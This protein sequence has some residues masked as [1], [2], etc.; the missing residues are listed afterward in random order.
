MTSRKRRQCRCD[1]FVVC[2]L[3]TPPH[4]ISSCF[5]IRP[6]LVSFSLFPIRS[7]SFDR[8]AMIISLPSSS[9]PADLSEGGHHRVTSVR[10]VD[11]LSSFKITTR[12]GSR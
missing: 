3:Y 11:Y 10:A 7:S 1:L 12:A 8:S 6:R 4:S 5:V 9:P 2:S